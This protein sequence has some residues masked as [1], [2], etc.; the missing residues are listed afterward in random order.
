LSS[1]YVSHHAQLDRSRIT[2]ELL[3]V[4]L[5]NHTGSEVGSNSLRRP[6]LTFGEI[7]LVLCLGYRREAIDRCFQKENMEEIMHAVVS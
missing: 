5:R 7:L 1:D 2:C 4:T 6:R 3:I